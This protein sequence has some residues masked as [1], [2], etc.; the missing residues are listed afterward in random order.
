MLSL[1]LIEFIVLKCLIVVNVSK[2]A[3]AEYSISP[4]SS[5]LVIYSNATAT[6]TYCYYSYSLQFQAY[7]ITIIYILT[8]NHSAFL[9]LQ[10]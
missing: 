3:P 6:I 1:F 8:S 9:D 7:P 10:D 2:L 5:S 4:L